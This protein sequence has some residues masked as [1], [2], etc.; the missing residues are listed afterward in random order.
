MEEHI[1]RETKVQVAKDLVCSFAQT[2]KGKSLDM[3]GML[4]LFESTYKKMDEVFPTPEKK[5]VGLGV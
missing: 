3:D 5:S 2:E 4:D 1:S